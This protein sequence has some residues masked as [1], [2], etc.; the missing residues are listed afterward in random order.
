MRTLIAARTLR[1]LGLIA[2][3][4]A[5][6]PAQTATR[7]MDE[8]LENERTGYPSHGVLR[9][10]DY[11]ADIQSG[12][13]APAATPLTTLAAPNIA[14]IDGHRA[15]GALVRRELTLTLQ[16]L[17]TEHGVAIVCLRN[18]H[19]LG[20]LAAVGRNLAN[21]C[22]HPLAVI[23]FCNFQ[24]HGPRVA[25]PG[26]S[27]ARLCTNPLLLAFPT[28]CADPFVLDMSTSTVSEGFVRRHAQGGEILPPGCLVDAACN[29]VRD[30]SRLYVSPAQA[31]LQ[32]LGGNLAGHK[33]YGMA[34]AAELFAGALA[35]A[36]HVARPGNPGNGGLFLAIDPARMPAG[37]DAIKAEATA[38]AGYCRASGHP[39]APARMPGEGYAARCTAAKTIT[40]L[41]LPTAVLA[42][43]RRFAGAAQEEDQHA[44]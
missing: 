44:K 14:I 24:G 8:L 18:A 32:P 27:L 9:L 34:V 1:K 17:A 20:R 6:A 19:H 37:L 16:K 35:G 13:L 4:R 12:T 36:S 21:S 39:K 33:G 38:I 23:G 29:D 26:G 11:I 2:L 3:I 42:E 30:P 31:T 7:V 25:P 40:M 41:A 15:F 22:K 28:A 10:P 5:G 43:I